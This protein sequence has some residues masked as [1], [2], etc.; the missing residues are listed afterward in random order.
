SVCCIGG[1]LEVVMG[2]LGS[3]AR[4]KGDAF[5]LL[6]EEHRQIKDLFEEFSSAPDVIS[7]QQ[8]AEQVL[9]KLML[10]GRVEEEVFYPAVRQSLNNNAKITDLVDEAVGQHYGVQRVITELQHMSVNDAG[11]DTKFRGLAESMKQHIAEEEHDIFPRAAQ[12]T[13]NWEHVGT[14]M[15]I[16]KVA[17]QGR[18]DSARNV[19][20]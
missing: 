16:T 14:Q 6:T 15:K 7:K 17:L 4:I 9:G 5:T 10:H 13:V 1:R 8:I 2:T 19:K 11:Y 18:E 3:I 12:G 20:F